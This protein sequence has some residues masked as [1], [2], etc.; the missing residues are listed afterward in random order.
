MRAS[1]DIV[2]R[3]DRLCSR[4][5]GARP[6]S[7]LLVEM[8]DLLAEGYLEALAGEAR[9]RRLAERLDALVEIVHQPAAAVEISRIALDKR[10]L[11]DHVAVLRDRL[12][13]M[14]EQFVRMRALAQSG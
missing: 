4:V 12:A 9:S 10:R 7:R 11:D 14:R 13:L 1:S 8:E 6:G 3:I 5:S 2:T